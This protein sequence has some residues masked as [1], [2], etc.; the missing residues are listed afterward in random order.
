MFDYSFEW[1]VLP[2]WRSS[3]DDEGDFFSG[4]NMSSF[5]WQGCSCA[6]YID[7]VVLEDSA[8][9]GEEGEIGTQ[10]EQDSQDRKRKR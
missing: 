6:L 4:E 10:C 1:V 9:A 8:L 2:G 3:I 7:I 5:C